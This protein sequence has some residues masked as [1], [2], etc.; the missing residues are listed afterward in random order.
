MLPDEPRRPIW[1]EGAVR[2]GGVLGVRSPHGEM[3]VLCVVVYTLA[4]THM[5]DP[6][7]AEAA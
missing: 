7:R 4:R 5:R 2:D 1:R 6:M 3:R